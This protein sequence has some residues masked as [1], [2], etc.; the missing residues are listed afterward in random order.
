MRHL[1]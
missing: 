1:W